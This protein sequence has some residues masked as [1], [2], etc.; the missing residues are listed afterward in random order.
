MLIA[1]GSKKFINMKFADIVGMTVITRY[2]SLTS[3]EQSNRF[4]ETQTFD[5]LVA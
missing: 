1:V 4:C 5:W 2:R 3:A